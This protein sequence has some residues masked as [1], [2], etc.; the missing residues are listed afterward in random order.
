MSNDS[1]S[2]DKA[3]G[4]WASNTF[5]FGRRVTAKK[6]HGVSFCCL[7][8]RHRGNGHSLQCEQGEKHSSNRQ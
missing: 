3:T 8:S 7:F 5:F 2:H 1:L 4:Q 6:R